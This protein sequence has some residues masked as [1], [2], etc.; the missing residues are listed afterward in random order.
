MD[1]LIGT[2][3]G[4]PGHPVPGARAGA[5][6]ATGAAGAAVVGGAGVP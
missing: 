1:G 2:A 4:P 3:A 5:A 6:G